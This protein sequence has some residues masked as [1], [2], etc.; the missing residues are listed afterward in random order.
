MHTI[1]V[2]VLAAGVLSGGLS[3]CHGPAGPIQPSATLAPPPAWAMA[4]PAADPD[5]DQYAWLDDYAA[6]LKAQN[7]GLKDQV[8]VLQRSWRTISRTTQ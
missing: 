4:A 7:G 1:P 8:R 5:P 2:F 3:G 6:A